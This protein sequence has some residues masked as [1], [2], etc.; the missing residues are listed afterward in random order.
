MTVLVGLGN[1]VISKELSFLN[2]EAKG[3]A[4]NYTD[5]CLLSDGT[6]AYYIHGV[7][8]FRM[9]FDYMME[10]VSMLHLMR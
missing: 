4:G 9:R 1:T 8:N 3:S 2:A 5:G 7:M 6:L 10:S